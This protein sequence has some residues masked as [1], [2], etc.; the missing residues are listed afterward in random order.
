[1]FKLKHIRKL[2]EIWTAIR[3]LADAQKRTEQR[4]DMFP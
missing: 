3:E 2:E 4:V 1:M